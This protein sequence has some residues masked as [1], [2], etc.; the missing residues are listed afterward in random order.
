MQ[1][2]GGGQRTDRERD[3]GRA[4]GLLDADRLEPVVQR[5]DGE[6]KRE[7]DQ[8]AARQSE[9]AHVSATGGQAGGAEARRLRSDSALVEPAGVCGRRRSIGRGNGARHRSCGVR[10]EQDSGIC[11]Q[12]AGASVQKHGR[13]AGPASGH[14]RRPRRDRLEPHRIRSTR[15]HER[16]DRSSGLWQHFLAKSLGSWGLVQKGRVTSKR[17][18]FCRA[19]ESAGFGGGDPHSSRKL[20]RA[21][22]RHLPWRWAWPTR[23]GIGGTN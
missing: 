6:L 4:V 21:A 11:E 22:K 2:H 7:D 17:C 18:C 5:R 3:D 13:A 19:E 15:H 20:P 9:G 12:A 23:G 8:A 10:V 16:H 1:A 14:H